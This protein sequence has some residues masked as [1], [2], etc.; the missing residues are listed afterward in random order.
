MTKDGFYA[1]LKSIPKSEIHLHSEGMIS[2]DTVNSF[3][4]RKRKTP[5]SGRELDKL[6]T[7]NSLKDF[8]RSFLTIQNL[9]EEPGD[10]EI[11]FDD[12]AGYLKD[13]NIVYCELFFAPSSFIQKGI[14]F[15]D[16]MSVIGKK[17]DEI[18][19]KYGITIKIIIDI[20]RTFGIENAAHNLVLA[21]RYKDGHIIGIG[22]GGDE[23]KGPARNFRKIFEE[24]RQSGFHTVAHAGED[25]GPRS[26]WDSLLLLKAERIGH[27]ITSIQDPKLMEYL[28]DKAI[29]LEICITSNVFTKK[30]VKKIED[31]PVRKLYDSGIMVTINTDDPTFFHTTTIDEYWNLYSKLNFSLE[32]IKNIIINGFK[33]CFLDDSSKKH[34]IR[35]AETAWKAYFD[36]HKEK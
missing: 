32:E 34:Y 22:L 14:K 17:I 8:I 1:L 16:M 36:N 11:L 28:R 33:A 20:S 13:N 21:E 2:L 4:K 19:L 9:F 15:S 30:I 12:A 18:K 24:A 26:I 35:T 23:L 31:H 29:P 6:F 25:E 10:F 5:G 27:G 7:Y 3:L